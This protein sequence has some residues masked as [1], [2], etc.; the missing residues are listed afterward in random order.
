MALDTNN[1][2][3]K[4]SSALSGFSNGQRAVVL[5]AIITLVGGGL[6]FAQWAS[7]PTMVPLYSNLSS[8][9]ASSV[10]QQLQSS[11]VTYEL[12]DGGGTVM[13]PQSKVYQLRLDM[14]AK[15]IPSGGSDGYK[16]LDKTGITTSD[17]IEHVDYQ[18][19]LEGELEN[20]IG[21]IQ[22]VSAASVHLVIPADDVFSADARK[23]SASVLIKNAPGKSLSTTQVTSI[24]NLVASAVEGMTADN[25]TVADDR[26][27]TLAAP[28]QDSTT[29]GDSDAQ[30]TATSGIENDINA[31]IQNLLTPVV[32]Q[33]KSVVSTTA[34]LNWDKVKST[35]DVYN[36]NN[37]TPTASSQS[38]S[39]ET[40]GG[41]GATGGATTGCLG[42]STPANNV[43]NTVGTGAGANGQG[44]SK[45]DSKQDNLVDRTVTQTE[46]TPGAIDRLTVAVLV[47]S[48]VPA[49]DQ[50]K[51]EALVTQAAGLQPSRGDAV[52]VSAMPFDTTAAKSAADELK[53]AE[54]AKKQ[55]QMMSLIKTGATFLVILIVLLILFITTR[56]KAK[57]Y[58]STPISMAELDAAMP[59]ALS[60][61]AAQALNALDG[62]AP[63]AELDSADALERQKV[64]QEITDLIEKQPDEVAQLLRNW[65][66]DRKN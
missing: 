10:T 58:T 21:S 40:Y 16:L 2:K 45:T 15:G 25:V 14:A 7:K 52:T 36:P 48:N 12:A 33:G 34:E 65:L 22:G 20:T 44:Y 6:F 3:N 4:A 1:L 62:M 19:A 43:C 27:R 41:S 32:G 63:M 61:P 39:S 53:S 29:G 50:A 26:G 38:A 8:S 59:P 9:D 42:S 56:K 30:H 51:I 49:A 46:K 47:D 17:F 24:T 5:I 57:R 37:K 13:V 35:S 11:K 66:N 60:A 18:R 31:K 28:G 55:E 54:K 23:P 64:D